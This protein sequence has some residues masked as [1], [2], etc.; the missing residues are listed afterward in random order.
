MPPLM[1]LRKRHGIARAGVFDSIN[2]TIRSL[3]TGQLAFSGSVPRIGNL[4][5]SEL[6]TGHGTGR[7]ALRLDISQ[8]PHNKGRTCQALMTH[9]TESPRKVDALLSRTSLRRK[10]RNRR[11]RPKKAARS[12]N[13]LNSSPRPA[14]SLQ[15]ATHRVA[16]PCWENGTLTHRVNDER[17]RPLHIY[18]QRSDRGIRRIFVG[19]ARR[20]L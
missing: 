13:R 14:D 10:R 11:R 9:S 6:R 1:L 19:W 15:A 12:G 7:K 17:G 8:A 2:Q 4:K 18:H 20:S 3:C 5:R 16:S